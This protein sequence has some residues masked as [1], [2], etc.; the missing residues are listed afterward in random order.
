MVEEANDHLDIEDVAGPR[1]RIPGKLV[2]CP[3]DFRILVD[4]VNEGKGEVDDG[5]GRGGNKIREGFVIAEEV[6]G[7]GGDG[8]KVEAAGPS[9]I[10]GDVPKDAI[11]DRR[12]L[13]T[14]ED[15]QEDV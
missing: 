11:G 9:E 2:E 7:G 5:S 8:T 6:G 1:R 4:L 10:G 15:A 3:T 14:K 13:M 12:T